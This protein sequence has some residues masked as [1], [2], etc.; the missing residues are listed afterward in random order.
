MR[1]LPTC[2]REWLSLVLFPFKAYTVLAVIIV[3]IWD[4]ALPR[5]S[6]ATIVADAGFLVIF[7]YWLSAV[8]L[9]V[10]GLI[11]AFAG[12]KG[13]GVV[14]LLFAGAALIIA[15]WLAPMFAFA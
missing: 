13:S 7:G 9:F 10:G 5:H 1:V 2:G 14:A 15:F 11:Q 12:P 4:A 6:Q 3:F 8:V